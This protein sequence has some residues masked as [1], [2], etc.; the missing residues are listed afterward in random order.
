M[1]VQFI[2]ISDESRARIVNMVKLLDRSR[3]RR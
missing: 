2:K 3:G 1:G